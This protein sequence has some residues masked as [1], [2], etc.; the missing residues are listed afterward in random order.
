[1]PDYLAAV[2]RGVDQAVAA[3]GESVTIYLS[4]GGTIACKAVPKHED[5]P[6]LDAV[7][8]ERVVNRVVL[9]VAKAQYPEVTL[10]ADK[11]KFPAVWARKGEGTVTWRVAGFEGDSTDPGSWLLKVMP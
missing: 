7:G 2:A 3:V 10:G 1:M 8:G 4:S 11:I 9:E 6:K 5:R